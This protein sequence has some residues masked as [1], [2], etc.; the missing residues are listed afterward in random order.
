LYGKLV[1]NYVQIVHETCVLCVGS[2]E[3]DDDTQFDIW[4]IWR[5]PCLDC[6]CWKLC[7]EISHFIVQSLA[8][9]F[10]LP[11]NSDWSIWEKVAQ[12]HRR[13]LILGTCSCPCCLRRQTQRTGIIR[14]S[15]SIKRGSGKGRAGWSTICQEIHP[16]CQL[17][18]L[19]SGSNWEKAFCI[20][21]QF[22]GVRIA[23]SL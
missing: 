13:P 9:S 7:G 6:W 3:Q 8:F 18:P 1:M 12:V 4:Q 5:S 10:C 21:W 15:R 2:F 23:Q 14:N 17:R 22:Y 19:G 11:H 20:G 16:R